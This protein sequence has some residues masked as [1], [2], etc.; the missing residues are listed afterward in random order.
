ML[1]TILITNDIQVAHCCDT[2]GV[3]FV[4][5]DLEINGKHQRQAHVNS[6]IS[7]HTIED[8][9]TIRQV[10][11]DSKLLVRINPLDYNSQ[12][13][14]ERVIAFGAD[15]IMLPMARTVDEVKR[16]SSLVDGRTETMLLVE[17]AAM[18][19]RIESVAEMGLVDHVHL[20]LNDLH[21]DLKLDFMFEVLA[22]P[23]VDS[24]ADVMKKFGIPFGIGGVAQLNS[25]MLSSNSII[26]QHARLGSNRVILSRGFKDALNGFATEEE[27]HRFLSTE[28]NKIRDYFKQTKD[29]QSWCTR[30]E[31][32]DQVRKLIR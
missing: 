30:L 12:E 22:S 4:M 9:R 5:V 11:N 27:Q 15:V 2:S 21:L 17:T 25:G 28:L 6:F 19:F 24:F 18:F 8:I 14:I 20:G 1:Q 3:D 23:Y 32:S 10:L 31:F 16:F 26:D 7:T 13:E 29:N